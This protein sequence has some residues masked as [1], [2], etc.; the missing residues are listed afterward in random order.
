[1][2][3]KKEVETEVKDKPLNRLAMMRQLVGEEKKRAI[4]EKVDIKFGSI[5]DF[6]GASVMHVQPTGWFAWDMLMKGYH[7]GRIF[8]L[9]GGESSGKTSTLLQLIEKMQMIFP[10]FVVEYVDAEQTINIPSI[11]RYA[12]FDK[13]RFF[14]MQENLIEEIFLKIEEHINAEAVDMIV[15]D[16]I[17][18]LQ[19]LNEQEKSLYENVMMEVARKLSRGC[20]RLYTLLP[21]KQVSVFIINQERM[22]SKG[23]FMVKDTMGGAAIKYATSARIEI[24][25]D[26]KTNAKIDADGSVCEVY[27]SF[28]T[29]KCKVAEP[30]KTT[31]SFLNVKYDRPYAFNMIEDVIEAGTRTGVL[32][33][34]GSYYYI[35]DKDGNEVE[36]FQGRANLFNRLAGDILIYLTLKFRIYAKM[37]EGYEFYTLYSKI[38]DVLNKEYYHTMKNIY[39]VQDV[40]PFDIIKLTGL[41]IDKLISEENI[42]E[43]QKYTSE[44][45]EIEQ[46]YVIPDLKQKSSLLEEETEEN[47]LPKIGEFDVIGEVMVNGK[48]EKY[49]I[50]GEI[51]GEDK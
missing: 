46:N 13:E 40:K 48:M 26:I 11:K 18:A 27:T 23:Q 51:I 19:T 43:G 8:E 39:N 34:R 1:M 49:G 2:A 21:K 30:Y 16:S 44:V 20:K 35:L 29:K 7:S 17:G 4:K 28:Y 50:G 31:Y 14:L 12:S 9:Y 38:V 15:I 6:K 47:P 42:L 24:K 22:T 33:Q 32:D 5:H 41:T 37:Y 36:K 10:E 45:L 25:S 3:K